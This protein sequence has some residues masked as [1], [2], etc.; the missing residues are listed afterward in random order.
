[1][2]NSHHGVPARQS[3]LDVCGKRTRDKLSRVDSVSLIRDGLF[4]RRVRRAHR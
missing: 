3:G 4:G 1:M 2:R